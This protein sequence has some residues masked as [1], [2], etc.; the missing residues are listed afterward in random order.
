MN[1]N[2]LHDFTYWCVTK[3]GPCFK[4][5]PLQSKSQG[6]VLHEA[7]GRPVVGNEVVD[8]ADDLRF[9]LWRVRAQSLTNVLLLRENV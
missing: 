9:V 3:G 1:T 6:Q 2:Q 5:C 4:G 7:P 8:L